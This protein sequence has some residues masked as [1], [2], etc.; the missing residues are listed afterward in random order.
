MCQPLCG[1]LRLNKA[2]LCPTGDPSLAGETDVFTVHHNTRP[3]SPIVLDCP[4]QPYASLGDS[5]ALH[6]RRAH[7]QLLPKSRQLNGSLAG[8]SGPSFLCQNQL[9]QGARRGAEQCW[10]L[11]GMLEPWP[12]RH[13]TPQHDGEEEHAVTIWVN[14]SLAPAGMS[15][16]HSL[17]PLQ[18][19]LPLGPLSPLP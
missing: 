3:C 16:S 17:L 4:S 10:G 14:S 13:P 6:V 5:S 11:R 9:P 18:C 8:S 19:P 1:A 15:L 2:L 12:L 7:R